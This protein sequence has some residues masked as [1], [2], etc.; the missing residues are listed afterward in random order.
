[1]NV[2]EIKVVHPLEKM[3]LSRFF[4]VIRCVIIFRRMV[5]VQNFQGN[6]SLSFF[7][8][9]SVSFRLF[10]PVKALPKPL[11]LLKYNKIG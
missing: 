10:E 6:F 5:V 8:G 4:I 3:K 1:M 11:N 2:L 9:K 7:K